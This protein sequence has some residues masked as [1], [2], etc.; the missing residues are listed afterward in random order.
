MR[1]SRRSCPACP[2]SR[3]PELPPELFE[4]EHDLV[5]H[6]ALRWMS[7]LAAR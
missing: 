3:S 1:N 2:K 7:R 4:G 6:P 5:Y